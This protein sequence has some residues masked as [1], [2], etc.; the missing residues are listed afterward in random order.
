MAMTTSTAS[1]ESRPRS[2]VKDAVGVTCQ[3]LTEQR[4]NIPCSVSGTVLVLTPS[5]SALLSERGRDMA[6]GPQRAYLGCVDLLERLEDV[7][8]AGLDG[9]GRQARSG[10][11][12]LLG[13]ELRRRGEADGRRRERDA[14]SGGGDEGTGS[15]A[16]HGCFWRRSKE[17]TGLARDRSSGEAATSS[18]LRLGISHDSPL[19]DSGPGEWHGGSE[20]G[21]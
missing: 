14:A 21:L 18:T 20:V 12:A 11:E 19:S 2:L 7:L 16:E 13:E 17:S 3:V 10:V 15:G 8:D 1:S 9:V 5:V 6:R 4:V